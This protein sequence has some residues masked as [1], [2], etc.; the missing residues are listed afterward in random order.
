MIFN[1]NFELHMRVKGFGLSI[2]CVII[3]TGLLVISFYSTSSDSNVCAIIG[4]LC[5]ICAGLFARKW[6][7]DTNNV[8][9]IDN[10]IEPIRYNTGATGTTRNIGATGNPLE[11]QILDKLKN[12]PVELLIVQ[13]DKLGPQPICVIC[14]EEFADN[15]PANAQLLAKC[16]TLNCGHRYHEPCIDK[17]LQQNDLNQCPVCRQ[18]K[19]AIFDFSDLNHVNWSTIETV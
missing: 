10:N 7:C 17:W 18:T 15:S 3:G 8:S 1:N 12:V 9:T 5:F 6:K 16:K 19:T 14:C 11:A 2:L 13:I 4:Y